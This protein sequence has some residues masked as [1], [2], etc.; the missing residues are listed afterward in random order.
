V[1]VVVLAVGRP[2]D[3]R[4]AAL[5]DDWAGRLRA[6]GVDY[7]T[8]SVPETRAGGRYSDAHVRERETRALLEAAR[9]PGRVVALD[10][11]G[12]AL[13]SEEFA[14][15]LERWATPRV[16]FLVGGPLGLDAGALAD[17]GFTLSLST[18]TF[19]HELA[20]AI[21]AEQ[22]YRATAILRGIPYHKGNPPRGRAG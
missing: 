17:V 18:L 12:S 19:P 11:A 20:R 9:G 21:L 13:T 22:I 1:K 5:H 3:P 15:R 4:L 6:L 16:A 10:P 7:E 8:G 2:R 14:R